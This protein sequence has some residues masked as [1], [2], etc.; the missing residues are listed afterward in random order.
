M[1]E[2]QGTRRRSDASIEV[3][4]L[5]V[6]GRLD[7]LSWIGSEFLLAVIS[8]AS[9]STGR[10]IRGW[11]VDGDVAQRLTAAR[12]G[13]VDGAEAKADVMLFQTARRSDRLMG[14]GQL[15]LERREEP[16]L[17]ED[18]EISHR[19]EPMRQFAETHLT[20][21]ASLP[22]QVARRVT[23]R[24]D[25]R[26]DVAADLFMLREAIRQ[27]LRRV[28]IEAAALAAGHVD[29]LWKI[30]GQGYYLEGWLLDR[31]SQLASVK[32]I[33][34]E[35][36]AVEL[37]DRVFRYE[38]SDVSE[39]FGVAI[40]QRLGFVAYFELRG[41]SSLLTGW[42]LQATDA[43]KSGFE[44]ALPPV[45]DDP[46][47]LRATILGDLPLE[48]PGTD[49]LRRDHIAPALTR[50]EQRISG[51]IR[52]DSIDQ[53]GE[54]PHEPAVTIIVPLY[55]RIEFLEHQLAQFVHDPEIAQ[56][57]LLYVLDSPEDAG[58]LR[59]FAEHLFDL[60]AVPFRLATL[61]G[62]GGFS[63]V[64]NLGASLAQGRLLLLLN[65]D[66]LPAE[67]GWLSRLAA[68]Y[69]EN[70]TIGA[71][72]PKLLY[73]D[74]S[75][76]H[77][78]LYFERAVGTNTWSNEHYFKGLHKDFP[79]ANVARA[80][81]AVTG[82]C[83]MISAELYNEFGGL[84]GEYIRGDYEDSD[85]CM[86]LRERGREAWYLP[87]VELYHLEGQ[88]YPSEERMLMSEYNRWLHTHNWAEKLGDHGR[89]T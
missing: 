65:S 88:S 83:L 19:A 68:F 16:V 4:D 89:A 62:N 23:R 86:R 53:H 79:A 82:A 22:D 40:T 30:D 37:I 60:Y 74:E 13:G 70:P 49:T 3:G 61:T 85:L 55:K 26:P 5:P 36:E 28:T 44:C 51:A 7:G 72:A 84:S 12:L 56:A 39:M 87:D 73:D 78:G 75:I 35:G 34:P 29:A 2:R 64:N 17:L 50:L 33:S 6:K 71:L 24:D 21:V 11:L 81:P 47:S 67:P 20:G 45:L 58:F 80:V 54:P 43:D 76:Q 31:P 66:V 14:G 38:R 69:D 32:I 1:A 9:L 48:L 10:S 27:P 25:P 57:D 8:G 18:S 41:R 15:A 63:T 42:V 77:A 46:R 52:V 59:P